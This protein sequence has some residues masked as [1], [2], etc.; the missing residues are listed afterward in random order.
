MG[1]IRVFVIAGVRCWFWSN[2]HGRHFHAQYDGH[3][4]V[5]V[6]FMED[7][8]DAMIEVKWVR[9]KISR[10]HR[11]ALCQYARQFRQQLLEQ[12]RREVRHN[13]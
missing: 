5:K 8:E 7:D 9:K 11:K 2:D 13:G 12:W 3:W 4:Q 10:Q 1:T 6:D